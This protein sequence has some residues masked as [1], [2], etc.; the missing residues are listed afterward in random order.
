MREG[1]DGD[2]ADGRVDNRA[3]RPGPWLDPQ[4]VHG[5]TRKAKPR[6]GGAPLSR[7]AEPVCLSSS[8]V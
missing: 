7:L 2:S 6:G 8:R 3:L 5:A 4:P 1:E